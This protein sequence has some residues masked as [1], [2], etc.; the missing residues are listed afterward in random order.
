MD[1]FIVESPGKIKTLQKYLGGRF[2][3]MASIGHC[4]EIDPKDQDAINIENN[5]TPKYIAAAKKSSV[6]KEIRA[7]AKKADTVYIASDPDREGEAIGWQLAHFAIKDMSKI[8]RVTFHEITKPAVLAAIKSP[9]TIND[10]LYHSQQARAVLDRLV[11]YKV[12]PVLW[13]KVCKGTSAGRVQSIG[14]KLIVERQKEIDAFVPDEYW[15]ISGKFFTDK[16]DEIIASYDSKGSK[17]GL[18]QLSTAKEANAAVE[19]MNKI[20]S[21]QI[22]SIE[23]T[24]KNRSPSP[25]FTT[26][27]MQQFAGN[28]FGWSGKHTMSVAQKLYEGSLITY[29]RT[30]SMNISKEAVDSARELIKTSYGS[31]YL[32]GKPKFYKG[33]SKGVQGAH[34]GIRPT[35]FEYSLKEAKT[36]LPGDQYRLYEAIYYKFI[37]CQM[38][39]AVFDVSKIVVTPKDTKDYVWVATG[40]ITKFDG[41]LKAWPYAKTKESELPDLV[42]GQE[43][44][45]KKIEPSQHFTKPPAAFNDSSLVKKLEELGVGRPSTYAT[46]PDTLLYRQY[47][48]KEGRAYKPTDLGKLVS[49]FLIDAFPEIMNPDY[50]ARIEDELDDVESGNKIWHECV[51]A[52]YV[53]LKKRLDAAYQAPSAKQAEETDIVCPTCKTYKLIKRRSRFGEF[54]GCAGYLE[55][56]KTKCKA[57]F[58]IGENGEPVA[59]AKPREMEGVLCDK[60][61]SKVIIRKS[62]RTGKEFGGCSKY[63]KCKRMFDLEGKPVEFK[64]KSYKKKT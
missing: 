21:W 43:L 26:S 3:V 10:D 25:L 20:D 64:R 27:T 35:H 59:K 9:G 50:T 54:Y 32:P 39:N 8:K 48:E 52:F 13:R 51:R 56:G 5:F 7:A 4:Y 28:A 19:G 17:G 41:F 14:L 24:E 49:S 12:S 44:V 6:I 33:K 62:S 53:E 61:G 60:C 45:L 1:L 42:Q 22:A 58:Q 11:G 31:D 38:T 55:K 40:Q 15:T 47:V 30:D 37:S 63:P 36:N 2:K 29:H 34:E 57:T 23:K 18:K 16:H 46:I